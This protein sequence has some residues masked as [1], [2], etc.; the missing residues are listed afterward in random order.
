MAGG[1]GAAAG[2]WAA[3]TPAR[4]AMAGMASG[5]VALAVADVL[6]RLV[7]RPSLVLAVGEVVI[8]HVPATIADEAITMFGGDDKAVLVGGILVVALG[9]ASIL[10]VVARRRF[11]VAV[12]GFTGFAAAG[13]VAGISRWRAAPVATAVVAATGATA[14]LLL[15]RRLLRGRRP[16]PLAQ[17]GRRRLL[18]TGAVAALVAALAAATG[19]R[20]GRPTAPGTAPGDVS[21]PRPA[22]PLPSPDAAASVDVGGVTPLFVPN[23]RF[24]RIDTA[25]VVPRIDVDSWRLGVTGMVG[26]PLSL[27]FRELLELPQVEADVTI[28][29]VSN[30]VGGELVG[31]A[32]WQGVL[33]TEILNRAG[34]LPAASQVVGRSVDG[35]TA[36]FPTATLDG[37]PAMVA[38]GMNGRPLPLTHGFPARLIVPGLYGYVSATKWLREI[39]LT[40]FEAFDGYWVPRGWAKKGPVKTMSR[41]DVPGAGATVASGRRAVAGVAWAPGRGVERVEVS[42]DQGPWVDASLARSLGSDSW[43]QWR[44]DWEATPGAHDLRVRATD[45]T[46]Q[47]QTATPSPPK[48]S[49]ATGYHAIRLTVR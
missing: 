8:D 44:Y 26:R 3:P 16:E 39:E 28:A 27:S 49:G 48:P 29:C 19:R 37:R 36:G 43:R 23:R 6:S 9:V 11:A 17:P 30:D 18:R 7:P 40:T 31:N 46:G 1:A 38:V 33:L 14:G 2:P 34:P 35:W 47:P 13:T 25:L 20:L 42:V 5:A 4:A 15:L 32:R 12:V 10:G 24:Y 45:A 21:L 41:I 22:Q